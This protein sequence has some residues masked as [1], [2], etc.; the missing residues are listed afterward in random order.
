MN[1]AVHATLASSWIISSGNVYGSTTT[2][3]RFIIMQISQISAEI[4][5]TSKTSCDLQTKLPKPV[6]TYVLV[7]CL[8]PL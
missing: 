1:F 3:Q 2:M 4:P 8:N 6:F 5:S 7:Q